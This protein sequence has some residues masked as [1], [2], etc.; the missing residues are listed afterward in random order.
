MREANLRPCRGKRYLPQSINA[1][2][3]H[4]VFKNQLGRDFDLPHFDGQDVL[5]T[6]DSVE[7]KC[8]L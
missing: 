3:E 5:Q 2:H 4:P 7:V 1:N 8:I 6:L